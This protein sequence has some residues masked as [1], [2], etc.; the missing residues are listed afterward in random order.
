MLVQVILVHLPATLKF[1]LSSYIYSPIFGKN[2]TQVLLKSVLI[3]LVTCLQEGYNPIIN[4]MDTDLA[5]LLSTVLSILVATIYTLTYGIIMVKIWSTWKT[6]ASQE[7]CRCCL[8]TNKHLISNHS[9]LQSVTLRK[10]VQSSDVWH[11][12]H[13]LCALLNG[14]THRTHFISASLTQNS[15]HRILNDT[16]Y[17]SWHTIHCSR[18]SHHSHCLSRRPPCVSC[19]LRIGCRAGARFSCFNIHIFNRI[20]ILKL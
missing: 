9:I 15:L 4:G 5:R 19:L 16:I 18:L 20:F 1:G 10:S 3:K 2:S 17:F 14:Y 6:Y 7:K 12:V 13:S 8:K 11:W